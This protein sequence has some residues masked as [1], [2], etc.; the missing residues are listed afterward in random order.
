MS[1]GDKEPKWEK[2]YDIASPSYIRYL[3]CDLSLFFNCQKGIDKVATS[4][5]Y[6]GRNILCLFNWFFE[7]KEHSYGCNF[8]KYGIV[9]PADNDLLEWW[10]M[11]VNDCV[12]WYA[13]YMKWHK[14]YK[15]ANEL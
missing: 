2:L 14:K 1:V 4:I 10:G 6:D 7:G 12:N 5:S 13:D 11:C 9:I 3:W 15:A 8:D